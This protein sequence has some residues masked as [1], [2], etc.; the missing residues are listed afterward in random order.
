MVKF[1]NTLNWARQN[2]ERLAQLLLRTEETET[3]GRNK[4]KS[5]N[6]LIKRLV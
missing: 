6:K 3:Y 5:E 1:L 2:P 4:T